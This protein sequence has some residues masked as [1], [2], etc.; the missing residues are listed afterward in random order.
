MLAI[1]LL[2]GVFTA[3]YAYKIDE[4]S[5]FVSNLCLLAWPIY[6]GYILYALLN[7]EHQIED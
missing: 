1:Y 6:L 5:G 3:L 7:N 4:E 2:F